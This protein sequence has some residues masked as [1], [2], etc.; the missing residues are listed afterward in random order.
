M[1]TKR[2]YSTTSI[3]ILL[4]WMASLAQ[5]S[6][7][8]FPTIITHSTAQI[9]FT[10]KITNRT[11]E[12][13]LLIFALPS[14]PGVPISAAFQNLEGIQPGSNTIVRS[15]EGWVGNSYFQWFS[16]S[17]RLKEIKQDGKFGGT[18]QVQYNKPILVTRSRKKRTPSSSLQATC[19]IHGTAG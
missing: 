16:I 18:I 15:K 6:I 2:A 4:T 3:L 1:L 17:L 14:H 5:G 11:A 13:V 7:T 19:R 8:Y 9:D 10:I 12:N